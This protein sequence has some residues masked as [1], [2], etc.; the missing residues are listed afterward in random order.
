MS[1]ASLSPIEQA[2]LEVVIAWHAAWAQMDDRT[3]QPRSWLRKVRA[4]VERMRKLS[5]AFVEHD[6]HFLRRKLR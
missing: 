1:S 5:K 3:D 4:V 6:P 2:A